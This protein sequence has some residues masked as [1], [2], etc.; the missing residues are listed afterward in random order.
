M[1]GA[2]L[3]DVAFAVLVVVADAAEMREKLA[4]G[5]GRVFL[6]E[7]GAIFLHGSVKIELAAFD[8]CRMATAVMGFE[9]EP[10]RY[11]VEEVAGVKSSRSDMPKPADQMGRPFCTT[12][13]ETPG[14]LLAVMKAE[15]VFSIWARFSL[16][17]RFSWARRPALAANAQA[18]A[19]SRSEEIVRTCL[20][21]ELFAGMAAPPARVY[22]RSRV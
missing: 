13:A 21:V 19:R 4:G 14:T 8:S 20:K 17:S 10:R 12:A 18:R 9:I 6:G 2:V 16:L 11:S 3:R 1:A 7:G 22:C 5:D 15:A